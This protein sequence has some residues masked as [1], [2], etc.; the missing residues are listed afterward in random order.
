MSTPKPL[1]EQD[2]QAI[3][4][5]LLESDYGRWFLSEYLVRNRS[6]ETRALLDA[7]G[8]LEA[9]ICEQHS[10]LQ[11]P[12]LRQIVQ[13]IDAALR[14]ALKDSLSGANEH[15]PTTN[16]ELSEGAVEMILEAV[17]DVHSFF[18]SLQVRN[19]HVRLYEKIETRLADIQKACAQLDANGGSMEPIRPLLRD[20][21][22]RIE[23]M[24]LVLGTAL[25]GSSADDPFSYRAG[26]ADDAMARRGEPSDV[27]IRE[28]LLRELSHALT[29]DIRKWP[30]RR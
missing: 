19:V 1:G 3:E 29:D 14:A 12:R 20:L 25:D 22:E 10:L 4:Q 2:Y 11:L 8:K 23:Q 7:L 17:E 24:N 15:S 28:E 26:G 16:P 30:L 6:D 27:K 9:Q 13:E 5:A 21:K 18:Q